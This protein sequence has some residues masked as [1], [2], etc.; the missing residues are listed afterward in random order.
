MST[1]VGAGPRSPSEP[2][3]SVP[4]VSALEALVKL[5]I[6]LGIVALLIIISAVGGSGAPKPD[7]VAKKLAAAGVPAQTGT[8]LAL[9]SFQTPAGVEVLG[10]VSTPPLALGITDTGFVAVVTDGDDQAE[11]V[12]AAL[13]REGGDDLRV[14]AVRNVA[15]VT[16]GGE[17]LRERIVAALS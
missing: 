14:D 7:A 17:D 2:S 6:I 1:T 8:V 15:V 3:A 10:T 11:A 5:V 13:A 12:A 9:G 16:R 4:R